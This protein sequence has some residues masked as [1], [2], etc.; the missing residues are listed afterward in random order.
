MYSPDKL[1][2]WL[3]KME[4]QGYNLKISSGIVYH[5]IEGKPRKVKYSADFQYKTDKGYFDIHRDAGWKPVLVQ[6]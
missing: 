6:R 2:R 1:E 5:F 3:E 4:E